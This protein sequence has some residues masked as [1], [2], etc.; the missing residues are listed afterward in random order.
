[1]HDYLNM[2]GIG[3]SNTCIILAKLSRDIIVM[4]V[5]ERTQVYS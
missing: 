1:M 3:I 4:I 5:M 2:E